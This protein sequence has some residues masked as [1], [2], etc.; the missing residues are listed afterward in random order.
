MCDGAGKAPAA[1]MR[2]RAE[3]GFCGKCRTEKAFIATRQYALCRECGVK[4]V[5]NLFQSA[6]IRGELARSG[7]RLVLGFS[8]GAASRTALRLLK[9]HL[10][11]PFQKILFEL[12]IV[13]V[14]CGAL[15][16]HSSEER[17]QTRAALAAAV[18]EEQIGELV[19]VRAEEAL[20]A[21]DLEQLAGSESAR[22]DVLRLLRDRALELYALRS[23]CNKILLAETSTRVGINAL[24]LTVLGRGAEL[25][26]A[27]ALSEARAE[28]Q[29]I[30]PLRD[31]SA[32]E[33]AWFAHVE[34]LRT[35][36][37]R[38]PAPAAT[39]A[40]L[41]LAQLTEDFVRSLARQFPA[42]TSV[43]MRTAAKLKT[44]GADSP[45]CLC[46]GHR[47][48]ELDVRGLCHG[49]VVLARELETEQPLPLS[50]LSRQ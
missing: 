25:G 35:H 40:R 42:T 29:I 48:F 16:G 27:T 30:R 7:D 1:F 12:S 31:V 19:W 23:G 49:C 2:P 20:A 36:H 18:A 37:V 3:F 8:G 9:M 5:R 26:G 33:T 45:L 34:H 13:H 41:G 14:D 24:V 43:V 21:G 50:P 39:R 44:P 11:A 47:V 28:V 46:C 17:E 4:N 22:E 15:L 10:T 38:V 6:L 32:K